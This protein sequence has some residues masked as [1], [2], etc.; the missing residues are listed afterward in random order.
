MIYAGLSELHKPG[1]DIFNNHKGIEET[2]LLAGMVGPVRAPS[3]GMFLGQQWEFAAQV[4]RLLSK[5]LTAAGV[6]L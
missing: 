6:L 1:C 3:S 4:L 2:C 5:V